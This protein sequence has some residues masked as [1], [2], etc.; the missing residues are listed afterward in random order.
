MA[1]YLSRVISA[2]GKGPPT[3]QEE[4][5]GTQQQQQQE[6][7][8]CGHE[9]CQMW[10]QVHLLCQRL[11]PTPLAGHTCVKCARQTGYIDQDVRRSIRITYVRRT[12]N[13]TESAVHPS[14]I[15]CSPTGPCA[16]LFHIREIAQ[17]VKICLFIENPS[18]ESKAP[19]QVPSKRI[20]C[21]DRY[22]ATQKI[23]LLR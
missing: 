16:T 19:N 14:P 11:Q 21:N 7:G 12:W 23:S 20:P 9:L 6:Q 22:T 1:K 3:L 13:H 18:P 8:C 10:H 2:G 17:P 15:C 5:S 4:K